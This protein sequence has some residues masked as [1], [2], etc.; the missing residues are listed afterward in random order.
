MPDEVFGGAR[1]QVTGI[2]KVAR[3]L[4]QVDRG[5]PAAIKAITTRIAVE[6]VPLMEGRAR[7]LGGSIAG[8]SGSLRA[9][10]STTGAA[11]RIGVGRNRR[12][13]P[14]AEYVRGAEFGSKTY[15]QFRSWRGSGATAGWFAYPTI[16][17][18]QGRIRRSSIRGI[19][20]LIRDAVA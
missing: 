8:V 17:A 16:R 1:V 7:A 10:G 14:Y 2:R 3:S 4:R 11:I 9:K 12:G 13:V 15:K 18:Q 6:L 5:L 19:N 20:D